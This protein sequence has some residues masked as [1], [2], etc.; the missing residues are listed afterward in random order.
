[1]YAEPPEFI[2]EQARGGIVS[3][4]T[5]FMITGGFEEK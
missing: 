1:M 4:N 2:A 5:K 3:G